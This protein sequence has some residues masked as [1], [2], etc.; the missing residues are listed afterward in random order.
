MIEF[1]ILNRKSTKI[2][3]QSNLHFICSNLAVHQDDLA[4]HGPTVLKLRVL[5]HGLAGL[6]ICQERSS[7]KTIKG[8]ELD[9]ILIIILLLSYGCRYFVQSTI[10][11][12]TH[13]SNRLKL[14]TIAFQSINTYKLTFY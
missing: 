10:S 3:L 11:H 6:Y 8:S 7:G 9:L 14:T 12:T 2:R 5:K 1:E 4:N 13:K